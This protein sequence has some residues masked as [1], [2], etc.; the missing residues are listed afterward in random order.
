M[1]ESEIQPPVKKTVTTP[2]PQD[3][4]GSERT[5]TPAAPSAH[6]HVPPSP[7]QQ[8][9]THTWKPDQ[10]PW[11]KVLLEVAA[12]LA[13]IAYT[14]AAWRQLGVMNGQLG[15][16]SKQYPE[17]KKSADAAKSAAETAKESL[18]QAQRAFLFTSIKYA[19]SPEGVHQ[20]YVEIRN[21]GTTPARSTTNQHNCEI[22]NLSPENFDYRD[23]PASTKPSLLTIG[24]QAIIN[25]D[26][27]YDLTQ[28]DVKRMRDESKSIYIWGW[29]HYRDVFPNSKPHVTEF[30]Y[31]LLPEMRGQG[32]LQ[33]RSP[34]CPT[35]NCTDDDCKA[36]LQGSNGMMVLKTAGC[37]P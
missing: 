18:T 15:E 30:C 7:P 33:L 13:V 32:T 36:K 14:I 31:R 2:S 8:R 26:G 10:T 19:I 22:S 35:H 34:T 17:I 28:D 3:T 5:V 23:F 27:E 16:M 1:A 4:P 9:R 25:M 12:L 11:W 20:Y 24:P 29:I 37:P 6:P 21:S